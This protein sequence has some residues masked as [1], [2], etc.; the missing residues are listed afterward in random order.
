MDKQNV[1]GVHPKVSVNGHQRRQVPYSVE[2]PYGFRLDLD[3]L[4]YVDDIE[5]GNTIKRV[6][7]QRRSRG[8]KLSVLHRNFSLP[9]YSYRPPWASTPALGPNAKSRLTD[10]QQVLEFG[11][12]E[13][14]PSGASGSPRV[15]YMTLRAMEDASIRAFDEQPPGVHVRPYLLRAT[16]MPVTALQRTSS[17]ASDDR[18]APAFG[19][20]SENGSAEDVFGERRGGSPS[21]DPSLRLQLAS[22]LRKIRE[23]E[24]QAR[25]VREMKAQIST[26]REDKERLL[27]RLRPSPT[28]AAGQGDVCTEGQGSNPRLQTPGSSGA[29]RNSETHSNVDRQRLPSPVPDQETECEQRESRLPDT[30]VETSLLPGGQAVLVVRETD[31]GD[32]G[33]TSRP[34]SGDIIPL[35]STALQ[36]RIADLEQKLCRCNIEREESSSLLKALTQ[37]NKL[38]KD[39]IKQLTERRSL[40]PG[41]NQEAVPS[42]L[43]AQRRDQATSS[44]QT[45]AAIALYATV[46]AS[47]LTAAKLLEASLTTCDQ[48]VEGNLLE[49]ARSGA[50]G[51]NPA[52]EV[53]PGSPEAGS[54]AEPNRPA[55]TAAVGL[56]IARIQALLQEQWECMSRGDPDNTL[57]QPGSKI[58]SIQAKLLSS[59]HTLSTLCTS[60]A[61]TAGAAHQAALKSIMKKSA[62]TEGLG[63]GATKKNLK[64]VGVNGGYETTSSED[65]SSEESMEEQRC[66]GREKDAVEERGG[67]AEESD[68]G[69]EEEQPGRELVDEDFTAACC[70]LKDRLEEVACP[71]NKMRQV[72]TVLYHVWFHVSS[73]KDSSAEAVALCLKQAQLSGPAM[74]RFL[75]NL[76]DGNDNMALHYSMSH[77]NFAI[78]KLLLDTG[79]CDVNHRNKAG[80]TAVMLAS[81]TAADAP[82]DI[83]V[84]RQLMEQADINAQASQA[85]Q[86]ALML[87]V[88]HGRTPM[89]GLLLA[90]RADVNVQDRH[91]STPLICACEHG[92]AQITRLLLEHGGC[93]ISLADK[94]GRTAFSV[95]LS[96]S[97]SEIADLL[98]AYSDSGPSGST[99]P[100]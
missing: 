15:S 51:E 33:S 16:S 45:D 64:F 42:G 23:L 98:R 86:T 74:L 14:G 5:K 88:S 43:D 39:R 84:A 70:Y 20:L 1:N 69:P 32:Q 75:V 72:L 93:D 36:E 4:K 96:S 59:I 73:Q 56:Y 26:L 22:A 78:V 49:L 19:G 18:A 65:S 6:H 46:K 38:K 99:S 91:G 95:A 7:I 76:A 17:E 66:E 54:P 25:T 34:T 89:V 77:S 58:S 82:E 83:V 63:V 71:D 27:L 30:T 40:E 81:L 67:D 41:A 97:H 100:Q 68:A 13:D 61:Q 37:E 50:A 28:N 48:I 94:E 87:A 44:T 90:A 85:G 2:T 29:P 10:A 21:S 35:S 9:G 55:T 11:A 8:P 24:E 57:Q 60:P 79:L 12:C 31:R 80:Y 3:F 47:S 92:H 52:D 62:S 53:L